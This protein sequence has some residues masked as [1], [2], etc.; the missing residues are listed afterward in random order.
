M[1]AVAVGLLGEFVGH[2]ASRGHIQ[3][4]EG[5]LVVF[6]GSHSVGKSQRAGAR[7]PG[8][9]CYAVWPGQTRSVRFRDHSACSTALS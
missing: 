2:Q 1:S 5:N 9:Q 7:A 3:D 8:V 4:D 6:F